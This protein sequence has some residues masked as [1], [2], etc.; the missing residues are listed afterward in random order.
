MICELETKRLHLR[1]IQLSDASATQA[2]FPRWEIVKHLNSRVPWPYPEN[3]AFNHYRD[4]LLPAMAREE[5]WH[6]G[7]W[8]K[9]GPHHLIGAISL[10]KGDH[11]NRGFWLGLPWQGKGL[12]TEATEAVNEYWFDVLRFPILR[13]PKAVTNHASRRISEKNGMRIVA[14]EEREYVAGKAVTE[15]WA[16]TAEEWRSRR[17]KQSS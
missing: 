1:P 11:G 15:V 3:G 10:M 9:G 6:W 4:I 14:T 12:M 2:L 17:G 8:L 7:L 5:E 16:I 13:A